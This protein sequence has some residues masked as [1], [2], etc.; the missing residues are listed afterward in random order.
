MSNYV[1]N[2]A[3]ML[4]RGRSRFDLS[5]SLYT[6]MSAGRLYPILCE[7][8]YPGDQFR[9]KQKA[10]VRTSVPFKRPIFDNIFLDVAYYFVPYRLIC[11]EW[12]DCITGGN[13]NPNEWV[14]PE[15]VDLPVQGSSSYVPYKTVMDYFGY[16]PGKSAKGLTLMPARALAKIWNDWFRDE[17]VDQP[18][19]IRTSGTSS[20]EVPNSGEWSATNYTGMCPPV[21]KKS[22]YFTTAMRGTQKG[23][24]VTLPINVVGQSKLTTGSL[25]DL[26]ASVQFGIRQPGIKDGTVPLALGTANPTG[27]RQL[28]GV[29]GSVESG[30]TYGVDRTNL[31]AGADGLSVQAP[32]VD[33]LYYAIALERILHRMAI[34]GSRY[35]EYIDSAFG[36]RSPD[37]R[38]QRSE[39]ISGTSYPL[40]V[41]QVAQT[42]A[43][44]DTAKLGE[45]GAFSLSNTFSRMSKAFV[46]HGYLIGV[47]CVRQFHTYQQGI[48]KFLTRKSRFDFYDPALQNIGEQ[49]LY[50][51]ELF[52]EGDDQGRIFGYQ[53]AW[54]ELRQRPN[55]VTGQMRSDAE[56]S[57][58]VYHLADDYNNAPTLSSDFIHET[59]LYIDRALGIA[60]TTGSP[61]SLP[62]Q[63]LLDFRF[64]IKAIRVLPT[65]GVPG[66]GRG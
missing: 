50:T 21:A 9:V 43:N 19:N 62:D 53:E 5:H 54:A 41:Q 18:V 56:D 39:Y 14:S 63:F 17:N 61:L 29:D 15:E 42:S 13:G 20:S 60:P 23:K 58:D 28:Q 24:A 16:V 6:S 51:G 26:N 27:G 25:Y 57:F 44:S 55:R 1:F 3:P 46:E 30:L 11:D 31:Y 34:G 2:N 36:V 22:D 37:A 12:E 59:R 35:V 52:R 65:Y 64:D 32:T 40:N 8:I 4:N 48:A 47:A 38:L 33:D 10:V 45:L 7:E 49:P 66:V